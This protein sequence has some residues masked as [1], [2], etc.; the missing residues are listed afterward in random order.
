MH[1]DL[2]FLFPDTQTLELSAREY[3]PE[4]VGKFLR[5]IGLD[6]HVAE[7]RKE[8]ISGEMLFE[9]TEEMLQEL[10]V[11]NSAEMTKRELG[12]NFFLNFVGTDK[13][14]KCKIPTSGS[15]GAHAEDVYMF[16]AASKSK[17]MLLMHLPMGIL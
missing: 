4:H 9:A 12:E 17:D 7:F 2:K 1:L 3:T 13:T 6:H 15:K 16:A 14:N 10:N 5:E 11:T 8:A